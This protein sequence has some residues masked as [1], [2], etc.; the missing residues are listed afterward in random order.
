MAKPGLRIS[1][2]SRQVRHQADTDLHRVAVVDHQ[3]VEGVVHIR[4]V[5]EEDLVAV[6]EDINLKKI[7]I[8]KDLE[9]QVF[10]NKPPFDQ[11]FFPI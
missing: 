3:A 7:Q 5:E 4:L 11:V 6:E 8:K 9:Y 10:F 2:E 1:K